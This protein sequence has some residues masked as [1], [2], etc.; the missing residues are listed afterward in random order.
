MR[1]QLRFEENQVWI[2]KFAGPHHHWVM[3]GIVGL[4]IWFGMMMYI[5]G[6]SCGI[7][8]KIQDKGLRYKLI[9]LCSGAA[10]VFFASY[11]NEII[12]DMPSAMIVSI[13][14]A[15]IFLGPRLDKEIL[16][17]NGE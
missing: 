7:I 8:W 17:S 4:I 1:A 14:W 15:F 12:N 6:K 10:G 11:G 16:K 5:L 2:Y 9:A 3:Y 13:S